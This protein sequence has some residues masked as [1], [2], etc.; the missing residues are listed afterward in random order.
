VSVALTALERDEEPDRDGF[1]LW[2]TKDGE[3]RPVRTP[4]W[5]EP[6]VTDA[7]GRFR[8]DGFT[9]KAV[10]RVALVHDRYIHEQAII[11]TEPELSGYRKA[12]Q[13]KPIPPRF[14]HVLETAR[15]IEGIVT[16][17]ETG[18]LLAGVHVEIGAMYDSP[19]LPG[20]FSATTDAQGRYRITGIAWDSPA[21]LV[22]QLIPDA[23]SGYLPDQHDRKGWPAGATELRWDLT[24]RKG[25]LARGRIIDA[26]T[27]RPIP[28]AQVACEVA[29]QTA[30]SDKEGYFA[31]WIDPGNRTLFVEGPTPDYQRVAARRSEDDGDEAVHH[32]HGYARLTI[33]P[34]GILAPVEIQL[35]KGATIFAQAVDP[36]GKPLRDVWVSGESVFVSFNHA[37]AGSG[38]CALGSYR[39]A[40]F[41]PGRTYRIFFF[42]DDRH[43]AGFA[44]LAARSEPAQPVSVPLQET[45]RV[46]GKL[47]RPDGT[48]D[49]QKGVHCHFL[50]TRDKVKLHPMDFLVQSRLLDYGF[51]A[52]REG[53]EKTNDEG[54]FTVSG[55][56]AGV[57]HYIAVWPP[58]SK[59]VQYIP[60]DP[61]RPGEVRDLGAVKPIVLT[62]QES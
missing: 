14:T 52:R 28:G 5:P 48:P 18:K 16:D 32:P 24:T 37:W 54:E 11:S 23:M 6:V 42:Q 9:E 44:D 35:K 30:L 46:R 49:R 31:L 50:L 27:K 7:E 10:A 61:L 33:T 13:L 55:L 56:V 17:K 51:A 53:S 1:G 2:A 60:V 25:K 8:L 34:E 21:G 15:P 4:Y 40:S 59:E 36:D 47:L 22:A 26:D 29:F 43:L 38:H 41:E 45:S 20:Y 57:R 62:D 58:S 19:N 39:S 3:G 12:W